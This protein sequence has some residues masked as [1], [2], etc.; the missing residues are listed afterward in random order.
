MVKTALKV[1]QATT[2]VAPKAPGQVSQFGLLR[3]RR[4]GPLFT[5]Q[6]LGAFNDNVFKQALFLILTFGGL[7]A[8]EAG[9]VLVN[10]AAGLFYG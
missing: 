6:F 2:D 5:T 10:L 7:L 4:L 9:G 3:T 1:D 8:T